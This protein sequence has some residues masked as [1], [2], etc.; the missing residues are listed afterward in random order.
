MP[1]RKDREDAVSAVVAVLL[2][3]A[4]AVALT[5]YVAMAD[6]ANIRRNLEE[7]SNDPPPETGFFA[8][9][10]DDYLVRPV[11]PDDVPLASSTL[12][13]VADGVRHSI[14]ALALAPQ[15]PAGAV[16]WG[17]GQT[18][19]LAGPSPSCL[20]PAADE[21]AFSVRSNGATIVALPP[22]PR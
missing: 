5:A 3:V 7:A 21:V 12:I 9:H 18:V 17:A 16:V 1:G 19:C 4:I 6:P 15:L 10:G 2:L 14:P 13:I 22:I 20:L 11:G 8:K